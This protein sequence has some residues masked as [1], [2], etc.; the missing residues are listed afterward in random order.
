MSKVKVYEEEVYSF[1]SYGTPYGDMLKVIE[2]YKVKAEET[3]ATEIT[4]SLEYEQFDD[5][6]FLQCT[7]YRSMTKQEEKEKAEEDERERLRLIE[8]LNSQLERLNRNV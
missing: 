1:N 3:G 5:G 6:R 8:N 7:G 4:F 2:E